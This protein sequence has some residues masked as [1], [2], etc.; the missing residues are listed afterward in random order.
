MSDRPEPYP[1]GD[2]LFTWDL[3]KA[4]K[5]FRERKITFEEAA[6][7]ACDGNAL[8]EPDPT[9]PKH[10]R[11]IGTSRD[12]RVLLVV[13][14]AIIQATLYR[15]ITVWKATPAEKRRYQ[16]QFEK[17]QRSPAGRTQVPG[18]NDPRTYVGFMAAHGI[19]RKPLPLLRRPSEG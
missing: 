6:S 12:G 11:S 15:I 13:E 18:S 14:A 8:I 10:G 1:C 17:G 4:A 3:D 7:A 5:V 16:A 19:P 9:N 2:I